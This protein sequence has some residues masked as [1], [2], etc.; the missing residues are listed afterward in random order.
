[1]AGKKISELSRWSIKEIEGID[2]GDILILV[3]INGVTG[4]LRASTLVQMI[5]EHAPEY[6]MAQVYSTIADLT[7]RLAAAEQTIEELTAKDAMFETTIEQIRNEQAIIDAAQ[8]SLINSNVESIS[9]INA[10]NATQDTAIDELRAMH[11]W[12]NYNH[13]HSGSGDDNS[14]DDTGNNSN[15]ESG[16]ESG[17][18]SG[19]QV[20]PSNPEEPVEP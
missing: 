8:T 11:D 17:N 20:E 18:D 2:A 16:N 19:N 14:G 3:S 10:T 5:S 13:D 4:A 7:S 12:E 15:N 6:Y 9:S 1:M